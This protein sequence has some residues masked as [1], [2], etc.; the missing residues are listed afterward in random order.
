MTA[1]EFAAIVFNASYYDCKL[2][3][4][5]TAADVTFDVV[6]N[7]ADIR[8]TI[9]DGEELLGEVSKL[10][11]LDE[12]GCDTGVP[13]AYTWVKVPT[14]GEQVKMRLYDRWTPEY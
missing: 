1:Q 4:W 9:H 11:Q 3:P 7:L 5:V 6:R 13:Y 8:Y 12:K 14:R 10:K 2:G